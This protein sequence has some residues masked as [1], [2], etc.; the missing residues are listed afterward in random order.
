MH[1]VQ[2]GQTRS[3]ALIGH[4][5]DGKT[6]LGESLLH[7]AGATLELGRVEDGSSVLNSLPEENDGHHTHT[8]T[9][10]LYAF[11]VDDYHFT[12]ID[13]PG[14]PNFQG[15][16]EVAL[17]AVDGAVLVIDAV[18]G[19]KSGTSRMLHMA[20]SNDVPVV[21]FLNGLDRDRANFDGAVASLS[22]LDANPVLLSMPVGSEDEFQGVVDL[23]DLSWHGAPEAAGELPDGV[24]E[25][26]QQLRETF[27]E[28]VA[29][30]DDALLEKYLEDGE[31]TRDE[32][33]RGLAAGV[34]RH[35]ILPVVCGSAERELGVDVMLRDLEVL[36]P[37]PT[38]RGEW[39][40]SDVAGDAPV[41]VKADP[42][43]PFSAVVFKTILD[44][45]AGTLSV[46]RVVSG[47]LRPDQTVL[48]ATRDAR[49]RVGKLLMPMGERHEEVDEAGPGDVVAVAKL[50]DVHTGDVLTCEKGGV[51]LRE[52]Q[53]PE[54]VISYAVAAHDRKEEDKV[55]AS[56]A[57]LAE[58]DPALSIGREPTTGE[59]LLSGRGELHIR[60]AVHKLERLFS[61][62]VDLRTPKVPYRETIRA[63]VQHV[64]GN[65]KKQSGGAGMY[66]VCFL[67][68]EPL[69]R[70]GGIEFEDKVVGGAIPRNLIPAVEKGV[71]EACEAGPLAGYPVVDV[72]ARCV[73]GKYHSVDSNEMAFKLAGSFALRSAVE[74]AKPVLLEPVMTIEVTVPDEHVGD[75]MGD[76]ASRRGTVQGTES[77]GREAVITASVPMSEILEYA[78]VLTSITGGKGMFHVHFSHYDELSAKLA[79]KVIEANAAPSA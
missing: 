28:A 59:F 20:E 37:S 66:G 42:E 43:A 18:E 24:S 35:A 54:G 63:S 77:A 71:R 73:D 2:V 65:L 30:H 33:I 56:L 29:E 32:I 8:V 75:V 36:L 53:M 51:H 44:R 34:R 55:F 79:Q 72:K 69:P 74:A 39:A 25:A 45:Y 22:N 49:M 60:T 76:L 1:N 52:L 58:E 70:G 14:D 13:T 23:I 5:G 4:A 57:K 68:L 16:G 46:L 17:Q 41:S 61:V 48:N 11:D 47:T 12:L 19:A 6:S 62:S 9:S 21:A 15:D 27:V 67:D 26:A 10:H 40:A 7:V 50:K 3:F 64:E 38:E 31:L 78:S